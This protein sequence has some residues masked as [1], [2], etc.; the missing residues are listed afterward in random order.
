MVDDAL[1][2]PK[3]GWERAFGFDPEPAAPNDAPA[4]AAFA[5]ATTSAAPLTWGPP[6]MDATPATE[7]ICGSALLQPNVVMAE[8]AFV[9]PGTSPLSLIPR[10]V[11]R[12]VGLGQ[13]AAASRGGDVM[14]CSSGESGTNL[15]PPMPWCC[16]SARR[17][18]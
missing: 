16:A 10:S 4:C 1:A 12:A 5:T 3:R 9:Q 15:P 17:N 14:D 13:Q 7:E 6:P 2:R 8:P 18:A 11:Q